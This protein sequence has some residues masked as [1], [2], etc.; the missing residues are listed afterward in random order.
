M[1]VCV[2]VVL[3]SSFKYYHDHDPS[4]PSPS[5]LLSPAQLSLSPGV[6]HRYRGTYLKRDGTATTTTTTTATDESS[7]WKEA[8]KW[9]VRAIAHSPQEGQAYN[10]MAVLAAYREE[11]R[12]DVLLQVRVVVVVGV[13]EM[14]ATTTTTPP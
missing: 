11:T 8:E 6:Y 10:Q 3:L 5:S 4:P 9:Y 1:E 13:G 7:S 2:L 14:L 12:E